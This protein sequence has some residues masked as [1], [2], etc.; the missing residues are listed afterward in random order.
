[1]WGGVWQAGSWMGAHTFVRCPYY[2]LCVSKQPAQTPCTIETCGGI[3]GCKMSCLCR[4]AY[5]VFRIHIL[6]RHKSTCGASICI[7]CITSMAIDIGHTYRHVHGARFGLTQEPVSSTFKV[8]SCLVTF[9]N[10]L[11]RVTSS[12]RASFPLV[13]LKYCLK[14]CRP[15]QDSRPTFQCFSFTK[16]PTNQ[17]A[18]YIFSSSIT[19]IHHV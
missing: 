7:C 17:L 3:L 18:S 2:E 9:R 1:M 19:Y 11:P 5:S 10:W 6:V 8:P 13:A 16:H 14:N 4:Y 15:R 12:L